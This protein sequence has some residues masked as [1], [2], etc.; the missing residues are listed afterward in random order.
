MTKFYLFQGIIQKL[1][2]MKYAL[3]LITL[4]VLQNGW[5]QQSATYDSVIAKQTGSDDYGMK[6]YVLAIL[7]KGPT[8]MEDQSKRKELLQGHL[9]NIGKLADEGKLVLAGPFMNDKDYSGIFIF[10]VKTK[11]EAQ[12]LSATDPAVKAGLFELEFHEWYGS[13]ALMKVSEF[14]KKLQK[15]DIM[16]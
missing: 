15:V 11:D 9:K 5:A 14:H 7:K 6:K 8:K 12:Q 3:L 13:A 2:M 16:K 4:V 10:N 1:S